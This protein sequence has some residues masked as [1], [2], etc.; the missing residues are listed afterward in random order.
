MTSTIRSTAIK[1]GNPS[2]QLRM[3]GLALGP[4]MQFREL[5]WNGVNAI[6]LEGVVGIV[7]TY[8][9]PQGKIV[10]VDTGCGMSREKMTTVLTRTLTSGNTRDG[11]VKDG[12]AGSNHG[13][14]FK[15]TALVQNPAGVIVR[16]LHDGAAHELAF[17]LIDGDYSVDHLLAD[18]PDGAR[19]IPV[20]LLDERIV[21]AGHGTEVRLLG[22]TAASKPGLQMGLGAGKVS[23]A[24]QVAEMACRVWETPKML[25]EGG[26]TVT[27]ADGSRQVVTG[28]LDRI[29]DTPGTDYG[30]VEIEDAIA[31]WFTLPAGT[32]FGCRMGLITE[33]EVYHPL[34][35][36]AAKLGLAECGIHT[37]HRIAVYFEVNPAKITPNLE[38]NALD[39]QG[40]QSLT[41]IVSGFR[42]AFAANLPAEIQAVMFEEAASSSEAL[43]VE[44]GRVNRAMRLL[45]LARPCRTV[46]PAE[47]KPRAARAATAVSSAVE[48]EPVEHDDDGVAV[49]FRGVTEM[50]ESFFEGASA[51]VD[52]ATAMITVDVESAIFVG[53]KEAMIGVY[54][55]QDRPDIQATIERVLRERLTIEVVSLFL[56]ARKLRAFGG[57]APAERFRASV[58][59]AL[60]SPITF[61]ESL[62]SHCAAAGLRVGK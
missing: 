6:D 56:G 36:S 28:V 58:D 20:G 35:G 27:N 46:E 15:V 17:K 48:V 10:V 52:A 13:Y 26:F 32:E 44:G 55:A 39:V 61:G 38:R 8:V 22:E 51:V 4:F 43:R 18:G 49:Q 25:K 11:K 21:E 23:F 40:G 31:H 41:K 57:V 3:Q 7:D 37:P 42:K 5:W 29:C 59:M 53:W 33:G 54:K 9:D 19:A 14:G 34:D 24:S 45:K 50:G 30:Y 1:G 62:R 12:A 16:T 60:A 2:A 47:A